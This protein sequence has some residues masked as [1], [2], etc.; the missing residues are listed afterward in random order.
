MARGLRGASRVLVVKREG[1]RS[2]VEAE[3]IFQAIREAHPDAT[4]DLVTGPA[5]QRLAKTAPYFDRVVATRP[6]L[7]P[8]ERKEFSRQ[9]KRVGYGM[10]YDLDGTK[11]SMELRAAMRGFRAPTWVG[12]KKPV[13]RNKRLLA[14]SALMGPGMRK[15]LRDSGLPLEERLPRLSW[16]GE[17]TNASANLDPSWFGISGPFGLFVP[18][19]NP[20]HRWP[21]EHY[22]EVAAAMGGEGITPVI[23]GGQDL[24]P[25]AYDVM[26]HAAELSRATGRAAIDLTGKADAAQLAV[27]ARHARF[28]LAGPSEELHLIAASGTPGVVLVPA[29]EDMQ[30]DA[31]YGREV[32]KLTASNMKNLTSDLAIMTLRNMG[33]IRGQSATGGRAFA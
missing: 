24:G 1:M 17:D 27:L 20:A 26:Q 11:E 6:N 21:A 19:S 18:A 32:V 23:V 14:N 5:L 30:S 28:F 33:L 13:D 9:L 16:M 8:Q 10:A 25:F 3:P 31:L 29:S 15:M 22:G 2:F 4:I 7:A 12:P